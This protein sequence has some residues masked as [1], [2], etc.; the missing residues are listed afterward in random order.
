MSAFTVSAD[1][2]WQILT[3]RETRP[4]VTGPKNDFDENPVTILVGSVRPSWDGHVILRGSRIKNDGMP[5]ALHAEIKVKASHECVQALGDEIV[6][7]I[8]RLAALAL[9]YET[10]ALA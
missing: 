4:Q 5:S 9:Q 3:D 6:G 2:S 7:Q 10:A 8:N 1:A